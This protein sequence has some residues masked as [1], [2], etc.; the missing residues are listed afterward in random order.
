M[1]SDLATKVIAIV[2]AVKRVPVETIRT[3]SSLEELGIDSLDKI[4]VL[5]ELESEFNI[6]IPDE[7]ARAIK[8]V[9]EIV[10]RLD[11]VLNRERKE[12]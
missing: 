6:D 3:D 9:G 11:Q 1:N 4:N 10:E 12:A 5:F 7:E 8:T 2:A